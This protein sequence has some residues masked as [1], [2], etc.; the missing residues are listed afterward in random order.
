MNYR[1]A[2]HAGNFA[3]V[4]KHAVLALVLEHMGLKRKPYRVIDTHA[5]IGSYRLDSDEA[6]R[7]GEW[8]QGIGRLLGP[9]APPLPAEIAGLLAPYLDVVRGCNDADKLEVYPGSPRLALALMRSDDRLVAAELHPDDAATLHRELARDGRAKVLA[10]DG[11]QALR[12]LLP[13]KER[14]GVVLVDPPFELAGEYDRLAKGLDQAMRRFAT[15][16]YLLWFPIKDRLAVA[17]FEA[18]LG[19]RGL[20]R[21]LW[22]E[23]HTEA[24]AAAERLAGSGLVVLNPPFRLE[25][26]LQ[27]LLPVLAERLATGPGGGCSLRRLDNGKHRPQSN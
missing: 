13:P 17:A 19:R 11:W 21:L 25:Q 10:L 1:H 20:D 2:F 18:A 22:V 7:S 6:T 12:S 26:Q 9:E 23:L 5:G 24:I 27:V 3:D 15:G 8:R 4:L 16:T 14:R